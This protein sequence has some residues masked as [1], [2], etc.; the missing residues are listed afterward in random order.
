MKNYTNKLTILLVLFMLSICSYGQKR[1]DHEN[2]LNVLATS[3]F[4]TKYIFWWYNS[5][6]GKWISENNDP[7]DQLNNVT[8][9]QTKVAIV[10]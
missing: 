3:P 4:L 2:T 1:V 8:S 6:R 9:L 7:N 5:D 10:I